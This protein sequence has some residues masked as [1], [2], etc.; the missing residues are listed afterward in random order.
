L[1][2]KFIILDD[3]FEDS[4]RKQIIDF[5][6][7]SDDPNHTSIWYNIGE[8]PIHEKIVDMARE[9]FDLSEMTCYEL[10]SNKAALGWHRDK[11]ERKRESNN[12]F[13]Y[14]LCTM[15]YYA[16]VEC[17]MGGEFMT[18]DIRYIPVTNRLVMFSSEVLHRVKPFNGR[19]LAITFNTWKER[20]YDH[21]WK[22]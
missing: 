7:N 6:Y 13:S 9:Y 8:N 16:E 4:I 19:R 11:N 10:W 17:L 20:E 22:N 1:K 3:V 2:D 5:N 14:P 15:V 18:K 12:V 21:D